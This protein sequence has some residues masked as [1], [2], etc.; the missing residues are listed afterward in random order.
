MEAAFM[1]ILDYDFRLS[2]HFHWN[3]PG[4]RK[5]NWKRRILLLN[6]IWKCDYYS[7]DELN[8]WIE[9]VGNVKWPK[10]CYLNLGR[11]IITNLFLN[12]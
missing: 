8:S 1:D 12:K 7:V 11:K 2:S 9:N 6:T 10:D 4:K 3:T 5:P